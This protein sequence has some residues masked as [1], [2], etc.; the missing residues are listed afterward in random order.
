MNKRLTDINKSEEAFTAYKP[1]F[2]RLAFEKDRLALEKLLSD[3]DRIF[4]FNEIQGQLKELIKL[5]HPTRKLNDADYDYLIDNHLNGLPM[6]EYGVWVYYPWS[7]RLVHIL[8]EHEFIEVRTNRNQYKITPEERDKLSKQK[9]GV[10]GLSVGQSISLT[11]ALER[12]F[13]E[14]RIADFDVLELSNLNRIR[15]GLSNLNLQKTVCVAREIL[16][17]DPFLN[18]TLFSDGITEDNIDDFFLKNGKLDLVI[19]E[20]DGL[21]IKILCRYKAKELKIPVFMESSDRGTI[22]IE[23]FDL[24]PDRT[25]L[26]GLI[27]HLDHKKLKYLKTNEEKIPYILPMLGTDTISKRMK[28]SMVE[29]EQTIT[30]WP[31]LASSVVFGG[32]IGADICR[33]IIL[34]QFHDSGRYI[35]DMEELVGNK[36]KINP[37]TERSFPSFPEITGEDMENTY[38]ELSIEIRSANFLL[39]EGTLFELINAANLAPSVGNN[40]PW[41]WF[42]KEGSLLLF[43]DKSIT[44]SFGDYDEVGSNVTMGACIENLILK[45]H[46]L[47]LNVTKNIFPLPEKPLLVAVFSFSEI[48][49]A[50]KQPTDYLVNYIEKRC[51]NRN[52]GKR[53][54]VDKSDIDSLKNIAQSIP[55]AVLHIIESD[56]DLEAIKNVIAACDRLRFMHPEG[57]HDFFTKEIRWTKE[58][59]EKTRDGLDIAAFDL[60]PSEVAGFK[61]ASDPDVIKYLTIWEGGKAF[62]KMTR[63]AVDSA[64][65]IAFLTMPTYNNVNYLL[66]GQCVQRIWLEATKRNLSIQP[67]LA[68]LFLF[69]RLIHGNGENIPAKMSDELKE[70]RKKFLTIFPIKENMGEIFLFKISLSSELQ[71][72]SLRKPVESVLTWT[73]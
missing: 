53:I 69:T 25:I 20:C 48:L 22:D 41:K 54:S 19:D 24:E 51:T 40:Q 27:D 58:D 63:K 38:N 17:I 5:L 2:F 61:M 42:Y 35:V 37:T 39:S 31:Q 47:G 49:P 15:S 9:I 12:S 56:A 73:K 55:G 8:D 44:I 11:L 67:M 60:T 46:H 6:E 36:I 32:G 4:I 33:R 7:N 30:T 68:P 16:E 64:A 59:C 14:L 66:G 43:H 71:V 21:D 45:A 18:V 13:G 10:I 28:A 52:N 50:Q 1:I 57:H 70:L 3:N 62:E 72:R 23:R 29:I 34:D 65:A 26:H